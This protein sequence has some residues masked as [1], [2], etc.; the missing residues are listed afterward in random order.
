MNSGRSF[1]RYYRS[2]IDQSG[3]G[4]LD[5]SGLS[6]QFFLASPD[7]FCLFRIDVAFI[8]IFF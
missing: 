1:F 7:D 3:Q 6:S 4:S 2:I 8:I 5:P